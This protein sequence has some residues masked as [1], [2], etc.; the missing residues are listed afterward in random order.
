MKPLTLKDPRKFLV[1]FQ[2]LKPSAARLL[3]YLVF[4][5]MDKFNIKYHEITE[6]M[7]IKNPYL[8]IKE[9]IEAG[10][11]VKGKNESE[12]LLNIKYFTE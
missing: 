9:L 5:Q 10:H 1:A 12:Y 3:V 8:A 7:G 11:L 2:D 6:R 4:L